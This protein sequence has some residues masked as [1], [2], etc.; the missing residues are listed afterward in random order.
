[1]TAATQAEMEAASSTTVF[2][3]PGRQQYHPSSAKGWL[4][5]NAATG[6]PTITA[7]YNITSL[8]DDAIGTF[9]INLTTAFSTANYAAASTGSRDTMIG[10]RT[11]GTL[12][13]SAFQIEAYDSSGNLVDRAY[14][15]VAFFGDQ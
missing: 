8:T 6:T 7:S 10:Q 14:N 3:S 11:T 13:A 12:T 1:V 5:F 4:V 2:V 15:A 9:T